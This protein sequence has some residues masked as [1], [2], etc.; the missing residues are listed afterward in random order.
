MIKNAD[1]LNEL[2]KLNGVDLIIADPPYV[3]SRKS[4][5]H[6]MKDRKNSR[7]GTMLGAWDY[8]F[9]NSPWIT[10]AAK[11][12]RAGASL[13]VFNAWTK[14]TIIEKS[15]A[16]NG[17]VYKDTLVWLKTNSMPRNRDRRYVP[18]IEMIQW[19]V[20]L[21]AKWTFNRQKSTYE[22]C[23]LPFASESG[24][25]FKR[26]HPTQK[27]LKLIEYLVKIHSNEGDLVVD[28]FLGSG[29]TA[30]VCKRTNRKFM[31]FEID[32]N[33]FKICEERLQKNS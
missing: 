11:S 2:A 3:I 23:V 25:G 29:T 21:G 32:D 18:N 7:T 27:P 33:Y 30:L 24:G 17:L 1:C 10:L 5:F 13:L 4:N 6:T 20:K 12:L 8:E 22:S 19:Y 31:G 9:D 14:S 16:E 28:P 26:Y 15:C